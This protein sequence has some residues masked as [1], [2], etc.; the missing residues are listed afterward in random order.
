LPLYNLATRLARYRSILE[1]FDRRCDSRV[2]NAFLKGPNPTEQE[3]LDPAILQ[4]IAAHMRGVLE[5]DYP[6]LCPLTVEVVPAVAPATTAS[7]Q[8]RFRP[9]AAARPG[10]LDAELVKSARFRELVSIEEDVRSIGPVPYVAVLERGANV[11]IKDSAALDRFIQERGRKG[12]TLSRY[13]GLGEM[14]A[15]ELW[16]TTMNP[17]GRTM[18]KVRVED[19]VRADEIFSILMGELVEPRREFIEKNALNVRNLDI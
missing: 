13:K 8:A 14:N 3:L 16:E 15:S 17:D 18:L 5:R 11:E 12:V 1:S 6:D 2:I 19:P 10:L 4:P 7:I 9:G